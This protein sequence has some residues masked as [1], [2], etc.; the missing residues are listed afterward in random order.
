MKPQSMFTRIGS[1]C[2]LMIMLFGAFV[3][4]AEAAAQ[5]KLNLSTAE[6]GKLGLFLSNFSELQ[7]TAWDSA[8]PDTA[9]LIRFGVWHNYLNN[10]DTAISS[11]KEGKLYI[12]KDKVAASVNKY[13]KLPL[14]RHASTK[15]YTFNGKGYVFDGADG[16]P[17][18]YVR[19]HEVYKL[20]TGG[21]K[22]LGKLYNP[23]VEE[24]EEFGKVTATVR[25]VTE[26]GSSRYIL[27]KLD[28]RY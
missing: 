20:Q 2:L 17:V 26:K 22:V 9:A 5:S 27:L 24:A 14:T 28:I 1:W 3:P 4:A 11:T 10:F 8:K 12:S 25:K 13:F 16:E 15:E 7:M 23:D 19:V 6:R 18:N 21:Y